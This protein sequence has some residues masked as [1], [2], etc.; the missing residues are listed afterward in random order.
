V[1]QG[2]LQ[3]NIK[4]AS[5]KGQSLFYGN[6]SD[7]NPID[8][9][10]VKVSLGTPEELEAAKEGLF[11]SVNQ[12][13]VSRDGAHSLRKL[14]KE[15]DDV[16]RLKLGADPPANM[17]SLFIKLRDGSKSVRMSARVLPPG[18]I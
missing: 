13:G 14:V 9:H 2:V 15:Y 17:K 12:A 3:P 7:D 11:T 16:F 6:I 4:F 1:G 8:N 18:P 10:D 5:L